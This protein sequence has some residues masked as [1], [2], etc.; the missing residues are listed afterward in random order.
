MVAL[1]NQTN[2]ESKPSYNEG[3]NCSLYSCE[4]S[5]TAEGQ[6]INFSYYVL[7]LSSVK[8]QTQILIR[9]SS[10]KQVVETWHVMNSFILN[11]TI[12]PASS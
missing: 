2:N 10:L 1:L 6:F 3:L 7:G 4:F 8:E 5:K 11:F 12:Q 9:A